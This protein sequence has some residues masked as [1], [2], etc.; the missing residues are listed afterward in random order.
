MELL[1]I[2][3]LTLNIRKYNIEVQGEYGTTTL[4][5]SSWNDH[6]N[7]AK[8]FLKRGVNICNNDNKTFT[9]TSV[10]KIKTRSNRSIIREFIL[11]VK[12]ECLSDESNIFSFAKALLK[13]LYYYSNIRYQEKYICQILTQK[14]ASG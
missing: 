8:E 1:I 6:L 10:K 3:G 4:I 14:L 11:K 5:R 13:I 9:A 7:V 2:N 12:T